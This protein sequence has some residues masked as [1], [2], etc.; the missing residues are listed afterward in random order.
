[1]LEQLDVNVKLRQNESQKLTTHLVPATPAG[2][3]K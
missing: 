3:K 1:M 2:A